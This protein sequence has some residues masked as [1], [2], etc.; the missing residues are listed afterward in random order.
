MGQFFRFVAILVLTLVG[1]GFGA[2]GLYGLGVSLTDLFG[3]GWERSSKEL[4]IVIS[5]LCIAV[6]IG[7]FFATRA[8]VRRLR[9][10]AQKDSR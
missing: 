5:V 1:F 8:L 7:C 9:A 10:V 6:A 4:I 2:C 3:P